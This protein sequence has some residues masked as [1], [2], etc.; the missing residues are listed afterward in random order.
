M[1]EFTKN[2]F[3]VLLYL[4]IAV[5]LIKGIK[6]NGKLSWIK[7]KWGDKGVRIANVV[8]VIASAACAIW[9]LR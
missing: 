3:V 9:T 6:S 7:D 2:A 4:M 1:Y 8:V 5:T